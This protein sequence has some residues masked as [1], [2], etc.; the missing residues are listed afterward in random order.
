MDWLKPKP[1]PKLDADA[2][3][4]DVAPHA[5]MVRADPYSF[6]VAHRRL[7]WLLRISAGTNIVLVFCLIVAVS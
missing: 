7:A 2:G 3:A 4:D 6:R 1:K 5:A